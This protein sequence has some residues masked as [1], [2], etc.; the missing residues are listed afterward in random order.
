MTAS[1]LAILLLVQLAAAT[2]L[3]GRFVWDFAHEFPVLAVPFAALVAASLFL[4]GLN[5]LKPA[6]ALVARPW[7]IAESGLLAAIPLGFLA[8]S[9]DCT[10]LSASGCTPFCTAI[11][12]VW[13]PA[14]AVVAV[15]YAATRKR[16]FLTTIAAMSLVP[17]A[18][19]CQCY[20]AGNGW[21]IDTIGASPVCYTWGTVVS[22]LAV[23]SLE[24]GSRTAATALLCAAVVGGATAFFIGHH[25]LHFPW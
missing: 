11:K 19:H 12:V 22:G 14:L 16:V 21:W 9:L 13:I 15:A 1:P 10:G 6:S 25:Y 3:L 23:S 18:P 4:F 20:N 24:S 2:V 5:T 7:R 17:L 8:S